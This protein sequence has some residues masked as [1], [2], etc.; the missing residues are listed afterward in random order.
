MGF[1][2][3][4]KLVRIQIL[5]SASLPPLIE[6]FDRGNSLPVDYST[7]ATAQPHSHPSQGDTSSGCRGG[8]HGGAHLAQV[9][10]SIL[11]PRTTCIL[12]LAS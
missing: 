6:V 3:K 4:L 9:P 12:S 8:H 1:S 11:L 2:L 10:H 7:L 5:G